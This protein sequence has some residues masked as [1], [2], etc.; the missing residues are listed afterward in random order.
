MRA[1]T[2]LFRDEE[3]LPAD[4]RPMVDLRPA[5]IP[6]TSGRKRFEK[7][8]DHAEQRWRETG[9]RNAWK[10]GITEERF[11]EMLREQDNCCAICSVEFGPTSRRVAIDHNHRTGEV[12]GILCAKCNLALGTFQD[13][14]YILKAAV[15]YLAER[16]H[17][18]PDIPTHD[19]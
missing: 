14:P 10:Y 5:R 9:R 8:G 13:S 1:V 11:W 19:E 16:G 6:D 3:S 12:R 18:G 15:R 4:D 7:W 2:S 17:Y